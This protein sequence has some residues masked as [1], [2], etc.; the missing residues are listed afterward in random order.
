MVALDHTRKMRELCEITSSK[1]IYVA[2][3][4][5]DGIPFYR[6]KEIIEKHRGERSIS[7]ELF[8]SE[9]KFNEIK[10]KFGAPEAG[11]VLL[12][13]VGTLGVPYVVKNTDRFYFKD[14]NLTWF[15]NF[16]GIDSRYL[17][18]WLLSPK[19]KAELNKC[20]I[21]SS[22]PAFTI[23]L[24]KD[25]R[26]D[27]PSLLK[28]QK[29]VMLLS[30]Y[31]DLIENNTRRIEILEETAQRIYREWFV[32]FRF[33]GYAKVRFIDS[34]IGRIPEEWD[35]KQ[36]G[37]VIEL[38]YG[39][40]LKAEYR[41]G[42]EVLVFGSSG[43]V[44]YHNEHLVK[45]PGII[46]GRKGN[47]GSIFW[48]DVDFFPIDTVFYVLTKLSLPYV[49]YHLRSMN[50]INNDAAVPGL[51]RNQAYSLDFLVPNRKA[52]DSFQEVVSP[53]SKKIRL[54]RLKNENLQKTRDILIP[55]LISGEINVLEMD[56]AI[57]EQA[58]GA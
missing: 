51:N 39:K 45:G 43:I 41:K 36:L 49:F 56:I 7:I 25:M 46:V 35:V 44:G 10:V 2:D 57:R 8:I 50:F 4:Q 58:N 22:Q 28:Q 19:G 29:T 5:S 24:L 40:A 23:V 6:S 55:K 3:Y 27:L 21:G 18:Y 15:R 12:T 32:D 31:D 13:S 54:L 33:P 52:L 37:D 47:V 26:I 14:G 48:S 42:G 34:S 16:N 9:E 30:R 17:Y 1:R 53:I 11:D 38:A 20:T